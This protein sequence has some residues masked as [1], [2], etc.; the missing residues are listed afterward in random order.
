MARPQLAVPLGS[1]AIR[2]SNELPCRPAVQPRSGGRSRP[3]V[4]PLTP[5]GRQ[6]LSDLWRSSG[7]GPEGRR[8]GCSKVGWSTIPRRPTPTHRSPP[9]LQVPAP[10]PRRPC[11]A[12]RKQRHN[13]ACWGVPLRGYALLAG[14]ARPGGRGRVATADQPSMTER[15]CGQSNNAELSPDRWCTRG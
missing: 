6:T 8:L 1:V 12:E 11:T 9:P 15:G 7:T 10:G 13:G 2:L 14:A 5:A 3:R 4:F